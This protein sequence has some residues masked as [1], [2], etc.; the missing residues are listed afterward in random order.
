[1]VITPSSKEAYPAFINAYASA[2]WPAANKALFIPI[3][4]LEPY[5]VAKVGWGMAATASNNA[6]VGV[7]E[8]TDLSAGRLD[9][10][11]SIGATAI[12]VTNA[13]QDSAVWRIARANLTA[14]S[15]STDSQT[16]TTASVT[17]KANRL[18]LMSVENSH[19]SSASAVSSIDNSGTWVSR[20]TVQYNTNLN[21]TSIWS[22]VP[23]TDYTGT[24]VINFG[25][26]TQTGCVWSLIE[27]S[28]VDTAT[29]HGIVQNA[30]GTGS[31][32]TPLATL[33]AFASAN[34]AT[35]AAHGHAAATATTP[36]TG[37][38]EMNDTTAATPAQALETSWRVDNDTTADATITSA[39]WGSCAVEVKADASPF[40][41]PVSTALYIAMS[42]DATAPT[43]AHAQP[44]VSGVIRESGHLE[45]TTTFPLP[46]NCTPVAATGVRVPLVGVSRRTL[47]G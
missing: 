1:M 45:L 35:F 22:F 7:Y 4:L 43:V 26:T 16:Y 17:L 44:S 27:M 14:S 31:S 46:S 13:V 39:Q 47:L 29:N 37:F 20:S 8:M 12:S 5:A 25:A 30:T 11:R 9:M 36:G 33:S 18:Y 38:T 23:T 15:D 10:I 32:T 19:A 6:D 24:L 42:V 41:L 2:T 28:G 21:R 40:V 3:R 34:N